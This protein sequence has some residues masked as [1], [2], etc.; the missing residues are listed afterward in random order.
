[1]GLVERYV[2]QLSRIL[3]YQFAS[4]GNVSSINR[5]AKN[6]SPR[7]FLWRISPLVA[8]CF[9]ATDRLYK[10]KQR[11]RFIDRKS[12]THYSAIILYALRFYF[13][14][15]S[16]ALFACIIT[17]DRSENCSER[18][19]LQYSSFAISQLWRYSSFHCPFHIKM[20]KLRISLSSFNINVG[21]K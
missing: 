6:A 11:V 5:S 8:N 14:L 4:R 17:L 19:C 15:S 13:S 18:Q 12:F 7:Q 9:V 3:Y 16:N 2:Q 20:H 21:Q 1:M 10:Q